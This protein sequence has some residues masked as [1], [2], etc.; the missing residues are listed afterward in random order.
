MEG[1]REIQQKLWRFHD[2]ALLRDLIPDANVRIKI[3]SK[4]L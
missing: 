2:G 3:G 4:G 1:K